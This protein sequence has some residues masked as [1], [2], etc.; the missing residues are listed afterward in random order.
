MAGDRC[1]VRERVELR[2]MAV[3]CDSAAPAAVRASMSSLRGLGWALGDA[4]L[5]AS[6]L[7]TS[8]VMHARRVHDRWLEVRVSRDFES[9]LIAV[10]GC[11]GYAIDELGRI[12][13]DALARRWRAEDDQIWAEVA[14]GGNG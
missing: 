1:T 13:I 8:I 4:M 9:I 6:E 14:L 7:V 12:M 2:V 10:A 5:I 11:E 3:R